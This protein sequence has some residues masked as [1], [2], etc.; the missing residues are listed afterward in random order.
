MPTNAF[1]AHQPI[2]SC[3]PSSTTTTLPLPLEVSCAGPRLNALTARGEAVDDPAS[4]CQQACQSHE[5]FVRSTSQCIL[6]FSPSFGAAYV[7]FNAPR[8]RS[9]RRTPLTTFAIGT[10]FADL[11]SPISHSAE[12]V[13]PCPLSAVRQSSRTPDRH[14]TV[15]RVKPCEDRRLED[16]YSDALRSQ[17]PTLRLR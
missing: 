11:K 17:N 4:P 9:S 8:Y 3:D 6:R 5:P 10:R 7:R 2:F 13:R 16:P 12:F 1:L 15:A 14:L